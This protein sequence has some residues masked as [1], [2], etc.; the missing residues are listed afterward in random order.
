MTDGSDDDSAHGA[1]DGSRVQWR[2]WGQ[3]A[4]DDAA[5]ES[6]PVLLWLTATWCDDCHEMAVETFGEPR[7]AANVN[8]GFVPIRVDVDRHPRVRERYNMGGFP[9]TV[10]LTPEGELLTGAT[11]LGPGGFRGILDRVRETWDAQGTDAGSVPRALAGN[12]TPAGDLDGEIGRHFAGQLDSQWDP[13]YAGWGTDAKFPLPRTVEFALKRD[14]TKATRMLDAIRRNLQGEDGGFARYAAARDW[15]DPHTERLLTDNAGL[16]RAFAHGYLYTGDENYRTAASDNTDYLRT[17]LRTGDAYG[18]SVGPDGNR[19]DL[20]A[21]AGGN[22]LLADALLTFS[23]YTDDETARNDAEGILHY[24]RSNLVDTDSGR[25]VHY[26]TDEETGPADV[27]ENAARVVGAFTT[28]ETVLGDGVEVA[29]TVADRAI[30]ELGD[31]AGFRDSPAEGVGLL[32]RPLRP[33]DGTIELAEG[34][35]DLAALTG[36]K[37]YHERAESALGAFA[38][39]A[40]RMGPQVAGYGSAVERCLHEP[41]VV[42]VGTDPGSDLHRAALRIAD[43]EKVVVPNAEDAPKGTAVLRG[44]DTEPAET[45][46][47]L[48]ERVAD[49]TAE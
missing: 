24:L 6:K 46:S 49:A 23:A 35:L 45:P 4:F 39:A 16:L 18:G 20:T 33:I 11:Y 26:R 47:E 3:D 38:G 15:S 2:E 41:L 5:R 10:F 48:M 34:L 29:R 43:H 17:E 19:R 25:V 14:R 13:E 30:T 7:T 27:L 31:E 9:S 1:D 44:R 12:P 21:Y 8:D 36:E 32:D 40:Q 28:A 22:A 37:R 42:A